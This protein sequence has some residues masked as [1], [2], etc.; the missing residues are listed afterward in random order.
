M[1]KPAASYASR[2]DLLYMHSVAMLLVNVMRAC[3]QGMLVFFGSYGSMLVSVWPR[4][5]II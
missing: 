5:L 3:P 2:A 1:P 4:L